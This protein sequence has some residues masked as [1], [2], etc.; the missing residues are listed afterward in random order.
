[1]A[2]PCMDPF[3]SQISIMLLSLPTHAYITLLFS[4][5]RVD[6]YFTLYIYGCTS[7]CSIHGSYACVG[8]R[9]Y[10]LALEEKVSFR[11]LCMALAVSKM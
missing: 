5:L 3:P 6:H 9:S 1:M 4:G 2:T 11:V 8:W 10:L 7:C